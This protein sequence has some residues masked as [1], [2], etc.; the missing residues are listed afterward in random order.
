[1]TVCI[2][3]ASCQQIGTFV[4]HLTSARTLS[5]EKLSPGVAKQKR[6]GVLFK[7][8]GDTFK[9]I[10]L[11]KRNDTVELKLLFTLWG[12]V[13][14][15]CNYHQ[16]YY[17]MGYTVKFGLHSSLSKRIAEEECHE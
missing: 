11:L 14:V 4:F 17:D 15:R 2:D 7:G 12:E 16:Q 5:T 3:A 13:Q 1:M 10:A 9:T 8:F 6:G